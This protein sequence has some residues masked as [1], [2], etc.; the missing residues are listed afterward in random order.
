VSISPSR[1]TTAQKLAAVTPYKWSP[2]NHRVGVETIEVCGVRLR[3][4]NKP[5]TVLDLAARALKPKYPEVMPLALEALERYT[6]TAPVYR[7]ERIAKDLGIR[8][9]AEW[10]RANARTPQIP[11]PRT[12]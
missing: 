6:E 10:A 12:P 9:A 3:M 8:K 7:I 5:R 4:T 11:A 1:S 2:D